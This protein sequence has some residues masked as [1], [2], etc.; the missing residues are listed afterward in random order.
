MFDYATIL[1]HWQDYPLI[2]VAYGDEVRGWARGLDA[3]H[4]C[5][6]HVPCAR[7]LMI[8]DIVTLDRDGPGFPRIAQ[9]LQHYYR[10]RW[11]VAYGAHADVEGT[12]ALDAAYATLYDTCVAAGCAIAR[13]PDPG[14]AVVNA[15]TDVDLRALLA[16]LG[17]VED[18]LTLD[19][20][21]RSCTTYA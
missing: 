4:G 20:P 18:K 7:G 2:M 1:A 19:T 6:E 8:Y 10:W 5:L 12:L 3:T 15:P 16:P 13:G 21:A 11:Y 14:L 17:L 9:V